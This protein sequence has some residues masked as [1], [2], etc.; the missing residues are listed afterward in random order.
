M[1]LALG[2]LVADRIKGK[3]YKNYPLII[4]KGILLHRKI[5]DY[6]DKH[7]I[8]KKASNLLFP[9]YR[10]F[11]K[12][13]IDM[14]FDH[15]LAKNWSDFH[16]IPLVEF[17]TTYYQFILNEK[18]IFPNNIQFFLQKLIDH[19]WLMKYTEFDDLKS[20]LWM[21]E[22]RIPYRSKISES[23]DDLKANYNYFQTL[24]FEFMLNIKQEVKVDNVS[25]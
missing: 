24:F 8:V 21:M 13:I 17:T 9:K 22:Q 5:D 16:P 10:H 19:D 7:P 12:V 23:V 25:L 20:I 4:Q 3:K 1:Y 2:N 14:Y 6:T 15:F 11:S 18:H